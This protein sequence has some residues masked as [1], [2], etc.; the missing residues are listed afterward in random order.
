[1]R[2][3]VK[4]LTASYPDGFRLPEK[5]DEN[6]ADYQNRLPRI[7]QALDGASPGQIRDA[8]RAGLR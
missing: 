7:R 5:F 2:R 4:D 6:L 3:A 8:C 1:M